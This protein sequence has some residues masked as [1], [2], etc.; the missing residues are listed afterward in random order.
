MRRCFSKRH[1]SGARERQLAL[2]TLRRK[3]CFTTPRVTALIRAPRPGAPSARDRCSPSGLTRA[4]GQEGRLGQFDG[5]GD[6]GAPEDRGLGRLQRGVAGVLPLR[7]GRQHVGAAGRVPVRLEEDEGRLHPPGP[8]GAPG[9]G[10]RSPPEAGLHRAH[11]P[12]RRLPLRRRRDPRRRPH[13]APV[14]PHQGGDHRADPVQRSRRPTSCSSR[15]RATPTRCP[16][17][18]SESPSPPSE[19]TDL[20]LGDEVYVGLFLCSHNPAVVERAVFRDVRIIRPAKDG[21]VPYRDYIGSV[22]EVL[23]VATGR[24]QVLYRSAQPFEAPNW[25]RDGSALIYNTQRPRRRRIAGASIASTSRPGRRPLIDTGSAIRNNNDH[26]L[27]FDGT[28]ARASATRARTTASPRSSPCPR[29]GARPSASAPWARP[30]VLPRLVAGRQ[31]PRLHRGAATTSSTS[32]RSRPTAAG[33]RSTSRTPRDWT[34]APSTPPT[35]ST[36]TSTPPAAGP[37]SSGG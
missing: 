27:S 31:V 29:R 1:G 18:A 37:C 13:L 11:Q 9:P 22:L 17:R 19:I 10:R 7:L 23:E 36:S 2:M 28:H 26:V 21:F 5:H 15:G 35:A 34:T 14:P 33:R 24:R 25:T 8:G 16:S 30:L 6:V 12:R 3:Q 20:P 4:I 32:T